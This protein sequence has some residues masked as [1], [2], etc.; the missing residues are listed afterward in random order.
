MRFL[1]FNAPQQ[2]N[3]MP[4][5]ANECAE[6]YAKQHERKRARTPFSFCHPRPYLCLERAQ[7]DAAKK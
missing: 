2:L 4:F 6:N 5:N 3:N 7:G 1:S